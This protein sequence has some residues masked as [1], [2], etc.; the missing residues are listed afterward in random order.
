MLA[1]VASNKPLLKMAQEKMQGDDSSISSSKLMSY[2]MI[3][4]YSQY[5]SIIQISDLF[6]FFKCFSAKEEHS[7]I[8]AVFLFS[9]TFLGGLTFSSKVGL[10]L[11]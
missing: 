7:L 4:K 10:T 11:R 9:F 2:Q 8:K 1:A 6:I 5:I 3:T